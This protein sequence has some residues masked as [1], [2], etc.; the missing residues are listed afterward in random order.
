MLSLEMMNER[1]P[2]LDTRCK[3][4]RHETVVSTYNMKASPYQQENTQR[5][6]L[7]R[8]KSMHRSGNCAMSVRNPS[9][10]LAF[11]FAPCKKKKKYDYIQNICPT[12]GIN[13]QK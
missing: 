7:K 13:A 8:T 6:K 10:K 1:E 12:F 4:P 5:N 11:N 3:W 9:V 2:A